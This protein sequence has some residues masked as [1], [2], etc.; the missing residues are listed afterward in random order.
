MVHHSMTARLFLMYVSIKIGYPKLFLCMLNF[1]WTWKLK[2]DENMV[3]LACCGIYHIET[4]ASFSKTFF[5]IF[6]VDSVRAQIC[7]KT[8]RKWVGLRLLAWKLNNTFSSM[9][10]CEHGV[11]KWVLGI[12]FPVV[13]P[14]I[15]KSLTITFQIV[16]IKIRRFHKVYNHVTVE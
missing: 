10:P 16:L 15:H 6:V 14:T 8:G 7:F 1:W 11:V 12:A 13:R 5:G 4:I 3:K 9:Q 2:V